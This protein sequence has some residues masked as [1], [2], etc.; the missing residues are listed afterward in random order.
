ML[1][2]PNEIEAVYVKKIFHVTTI[3]LS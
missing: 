2:A 3:S 1:V